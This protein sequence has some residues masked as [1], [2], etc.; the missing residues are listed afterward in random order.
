MGD[1][2]EQAGRARAA[3]A[4]GWRWSPRLRGWRARRSIAA[5]TIWTRRP[6]GRAHPPSRAAAGAA[7]GHH[8]PGLREASE[9]SG[10]AGDFGRSDASAGVGVEELGQAGGGVDAMGH[11]GQPR[12][13]RAELRKLGF[14]RQ[15][16][17]KADEGSKHPDRDAQF[18]Y[19]NAR[20]LAAQAAGEPVISVDTKKKEL[21]GDFK[22]GGRTIGPRASRC[23]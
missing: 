21:V 14:S 15:G 12:H 6:A 23:A 10:R 16:N 3:G 5:R 7:L 18:E 13:R 1:V 2:R 19:I 17:R 11:R 22:N 9:A 4:A 20:S 8:D